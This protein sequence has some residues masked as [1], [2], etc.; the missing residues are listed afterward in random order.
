M[1]RT[2][3]R[4]LSAFLSFC[5]VVSCIPGINF[6]ALAETVSYDLWVGGT[7][8]T[9][10]NA[11]NI[12][13]DGKARYNAETST[14]TLDGY[15]YSGD[16]YKR[17]I[18]EGSGV[19]N[20]YYAIYAKQ[21]LNIVLEQENSVICSQSSSNPYISGYGIYVINGNLKI[22]ADNDTG[23]LNA[24]G[25]NYGIFCN[26]NFEYVSGSVTAD[27]KTGIYGKAVA[28][29]GGSVTADG[30]TAISCNTIAVSGGTVNATASSSFGIYAN[31]SVTISGDAKVIASGT[32]MAIRGKVKNSIAGCG[33]TDVNGTEGKTVIA[34]NTDVQYLDQKKVQFPPDHTHDFG[35]SYALSTVNTENDTI[36]ANCSADD[37]YLENHIATMTIVAS[38]N[39]DGTATL[40]G[41][42]A[43]FGV[44]DSDIEYSTDG[45]TT[46]SNTASSGASSYQA[47][48]IVTD[49]ADSS[50][51]YTAKISYGMYAINSAGTPDHGSF[52]IPSSAANSASVT[53]TATP[54]AGYELGALTV[55]TA[56]GSTVSVT[57]SGNKG[58]FTMPAEDVTVT[59]NFVPRSVPVTLDVRT[60]SGTS[61]KASLLTESFA[62]AENNFAQ[63][64]GEKFILSVSADEGCDYTISLDDKSQYVTAFSNEDYQRYI[65]YA[66]EQKI[67]MPTNMDLYWVTMPNIAS[68]SLYIRVTFITTKTFTILYKPTEDTNEVWC[69]F[70]AKVSD[71]DQDFAVKMTKDAVMGDSAVWS[72]KMATAFD[73]TEIAFVTTQEA[74]ST[75]TKSNAKVS[76]S[77]DWNAITGGNYL[78]IGGNAKTVV[79]AFVSD[80]SALSDY[81]SATATFKAGANT[82]G[83]TYQLAVCGTDASGNVTTAGTVK[84]PAAPTATDKKFDGWRGFEGTA[85]NLTEKIYNPGD[86]I[87]VSQN[88][89]LNAVWK[90]AD[91]KIT[92]DLNGGTGVGASTT[93]EYEKKLSL[94]EPTRYGFAFDG[95]TVSESVSENG[96]FF[97]KDS[98]FDFDTPITA[99]LKLTAQWKH[100]HSNTYIQIS[101]DG[102]A[103]S[104]QRNS[105]HF[106]LCGCGRSVLEAHSFDSDGKCVCGYNP[107]EEEKVELTISYEQW[108]HNGQKISSMGDVTEEVTKNEFASAYAPETWDE[109][110]LSKWQY[111]TDDGS[112]WYDLTSDVMAY[113]QVS[114]N[115]K[116]R[117]IY[118]NPT[119]VPQ[120]EMSVRRYVEEVALPDK[121]YPIN[122]VLFQMNY[123]LPGGYTYVDSGVR[124]G[125][126]GG[127]S[128]YE[129]KERKPT[130]G[131]KA[132]VAGVS[133]AVGFLSG[134][135]GDALLGGWDA[136]NSLESSF[137]YADREN[138]VLNEMSAATL[139]RYMYENKPVNV[140]KYPPIYWDYT[141]RTKGQNGS[142]NALPRVDFIL[143][144]DGNHYIYGIAWLRY[145]DTNG[146]VQTI[147]T[148]A[149]PTT[150]DN[151][152]TYTVTKTGY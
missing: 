152:P 109:C 7:Q 108:N 2:R 132:L 110:N 142:L 116:L 139:A 145:K 59:A 150:R 6:T 112:H 79:A 135:L 55:K 90:P 141:T 77:A 98:Q 43:D 39:N 83:V 46:W 123:K 29:S 40:T 97:A 121:T 3:Q 54:D 95:W 137:Y 99:N 105:F 133:A 117:A 103:L 120:I 65:A 12:S 106:A 114:C 34:V 64:V 87:S 62:A 138:S 11:S 61:C 31:D 42:A 21:D 50:K 36:T 67:S 8:V 57:L 75:A 24:Q 122:T 41:D 47:R 10:E 4:F 130:A 5:M 33:W 26:G 51:T 80:A 147:Y 18:G 149:L 68:G 52:T 126:N 17:T 88:T 69:K 84:A 125:D 136:A 71:S 66:N 143:K 35:T 127:I 32:S 74:L 15:T 1:K 118:I 44:S 28:V 86:S 151:I 19:N 70:T 100:V 45:G 129:L 56:G 38:S 63:K 22:E 96:V 13:G 82:G 48:I 115:T 76:Q 60:I 124:L 37:C 131:E 23:S 146:N 101:A 20:Y 92:L 85:P 104:R 9:S 25:K 148:D 78:I 49:S 94:R 140:E 30:E 111:S 91:L 53:I 119:T 89:T 14:L 134:G 72:V 128:Y 81:D 16:G 27:G 73:P 58:T 93:V 102:S 113:C 107:A 144:N